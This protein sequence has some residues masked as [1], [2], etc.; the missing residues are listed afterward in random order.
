MEKVLNNEFYDIENRSIQLVYF[1]D[2]DSDLHS[3]R[4]EH[5]VSW[6]RTKK[7]LIERFAQNS[8]RDKRL[9]LWDI[10]TFKSFVISRGI[11]GITDEERKIIEDSQIDFNENSSIRYE[12]LEREKNNL[13]ELIMQRK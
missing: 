2:V 7:A 13:L 6:M 1:G 3:Y 4:D 9:R 10:I 12:F 11:D 8:L 5:N